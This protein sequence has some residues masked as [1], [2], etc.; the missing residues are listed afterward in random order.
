MQDELFNCRWHGFA[1][2]PP[3]C[4]RALCEIIEVCPSLSPFVILCIDPLLSPLP[5]AR[6]SF[7]VNPFGAPVQTRPCPTHNPSLNLALF[8]DPTIARRPAQR[9]KE[10]KKEQRHY[11]HPQLPDPLPSPPF[12][13]TPSEQK[14][15]VHARPHTRLPSH[16]QAQDSTSRQRHENSIAPLPLSG[17]SSWSRTRDKH[18]HPNM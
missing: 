18:A 10:G 14:P 12:S 13:D 4:Q 17:H 1:W 6:R 15:G 5:P 3:I 7:A 11:R 16:E 9:K 8:K 2:G